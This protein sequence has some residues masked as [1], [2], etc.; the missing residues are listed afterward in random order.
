M[1]A[2]LTTYVVVAIVAATLIAGLIVGAQRDDSSGPVDL[3]IHNARVYTADAHGTIAQAIA[4]RGN[5]ILRVGNDRDVMRYRRPQTRVIDAEGAAVLPGFNDA[6]ASLV[7]EGRAREDVDLSDARTGEQVAQRVMAWLEVHPGAAWVVG[8]GWS[9][10][11]SP[12]RQLRSQLDEAAPRIPTVLYSADGETAWLNTAALRAAGISRRTP[13]GAAG[14]ARDR[15]GEP[16]GILRGRALDL[17]RRVAPSPVPAEAALT[18]AL[19]DSARLGI[20]SVHDFASDASAVEFYRRLHADD[21][22]SR[23]AR[24]YVGVPIASVEAAAALDGLERRLPD[25]PLFKTGLAYVTPEAPPATLEAIVAAIDRAEWQPAVESATADGVSAALGAFRAAARANPSRETE[26]RN[27][28]ELVREMNAADLP[29]LKGHALVATLAPGDLLQM[30]PPQS[31]RGSVPSLDVIDWPMRSLER[32]GARLAFA[33]DG[34]DHPVDPIAAIA[35]AVSERP[36][37]S[38][39]S[40]TLKAAINAW[41]SGAAWASF[42]EHR[43]GALEPGML[44]DLVVLSDDIFKMPVEEIARVTVALTVLDVYRRASS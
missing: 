34:P 41:T 42:D 3:I 26:R 39:E 16:T 9:P 43:K 12:D 33:S 6:H 28:L 22:E 31:P 7:A 14:I 36:A 8:R 5:K 17:V 37:G 25:D 18:Q 27:R 19:L 21:R 24:V 23:L 29:L 32:A 11:A 30:R 40:L 44:A 13:A 10:T 35:A 4:I 1:A 38:D 2:R 20:T 15:R